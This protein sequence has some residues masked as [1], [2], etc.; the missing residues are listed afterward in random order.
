MPYVPD[1]RF[2]VDPLTATM[3]SYRECLVKDARYIIV[4][5][6]DAG[7]AMLAE[8]EAKKAAEPPAPPAPDKKIRSRVR[9]KKN[10]DP[11]ISEDEDAVLA[12][13]IAELDAEN[14]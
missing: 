9:L 14:G 1:P 12:A 11:V 10:V 8:L 13:A 3:Y 7:R 4:D 2:H 5:D 6:I